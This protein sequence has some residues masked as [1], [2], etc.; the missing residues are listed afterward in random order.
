[1]KRNGFLIARDQIGQLEGLPHLHIGRNGE[2]ILG[3]NGNHRIAI[4]KVLG[5]QS[6]PCWVRGRHLLWQQIR[7]SVAEAMIN[8]FTIGP[9]FPFTNHPDLADLLEP[10]ANKPHN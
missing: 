10:S 1:M 3:N 9:D 8:S 5:I 4:A 2:L 7:E 6:V